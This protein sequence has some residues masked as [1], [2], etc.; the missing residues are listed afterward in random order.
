MLSTLS[1]NQHLVLKMTI[2]PVNTIPSFV[3]EKLFHF[4]DDR[5]MTL[6]RRV[7]NQFKAIID[8]PKMEPYWR[9]FMEKRFSHLKSMY[10]YREGIS[11]VKFFL[12]YAKRENDAVNDRDFFGN[13]L[14]DPADMAEGFKSLKKAA[15][16][17]LAAA[18]NTL[19]K[20]YQSARFGTPVNHEEAYKYFKLAADQG[21]ASARFHLGVCYE[22]GLGTP[23]NRGEAFKYVKMA[24]D[25]GGAA[26]QYALGLYY[27]QGIGTPVDHKEAFKYVKMAADQGM[28]LAQYALGS[29]YE[30]GNGTPAN[31]EEAVKYYKMAADQGF[32]PA[33][34]RLV[35]LRS[36]GTPHTFP[37]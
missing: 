21:L 15:D 35:G 30:Q 12:K 1:F 7:S 34:Q 28:A 3:L 8:N 29:Y 14:L 11:W 6:S 25:Q 27:K 19:G 36:G 23:V 13:Q 20:F 16:Q 32:E 24:A 37:Q 4:L 22:K 5:A 9:D 2:G 26:K 18:Q 17:G 33:K 31:L 10:Q